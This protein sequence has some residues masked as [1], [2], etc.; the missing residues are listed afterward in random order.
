[1]SNQAGNTQYTQEIV[2]TTIPFDVCMKCNRKLIYGIASLPGAL[3]PTVNGKIC[4][5]CGRFHKDNAPDLERYLAANFYL[6][7]YRSSKANLWE[8][9]REE[10]IEKDNESNHIHH[11]N[12]TP[13]ASLLIVVQD[14]KGK[15]HEVFIVTDRAFEDRT[16]NI[17]YCWS[18]TALILMTYA[19]HKEH[20]GRSFYV[21]QKK[22]SIKKVYIGNDYRGACLRTPPAIYLRKNG[23]YHDPRHPKFPLV[24]ALVYS[25]FSRH[26]E[27]MTV[28]YDT[29]EDVYYVDSSKFRE[30]IYKHGNP[31][32]HIGFYKRDGNY[33]FDWSDLNDSSFL[34]DYGYNVSYRDNLPAGLRHNLLAELVDLQLATVSEIVSHLNFCISTHMQNKSAVDCWK[35]DRE[36]IS[37]YKVNPQRFLIAGD[38]KQQEKS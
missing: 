3:L 38:I 34:M 28:T 31:G 5:S 20:L 19:F 27:G 8:Y 4:P 36:F 37:T 15:E 9:A 22:Y 26:Y 21:K 33:G 29:D 24:I 23:G 10:I 1:M 16:K 30:F 35:D 11:L 6:E 18:R 25:P 17:I 32:V 14:E 2:V 7:R 12:L 13:G